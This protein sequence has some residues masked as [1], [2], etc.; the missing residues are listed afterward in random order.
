MVLATVKEYFDAKVMI[1]CSVYPLNHLKS[2]TICPNAL[3]QH[4]KGDL[5]CTDTTSRTKKSLAMFG[6]CH[7]NT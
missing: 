2:T 5:V 6:K 3:L 1:K 4:L 7:N